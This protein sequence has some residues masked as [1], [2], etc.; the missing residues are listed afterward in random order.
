MVNINIQRFG[1]IPKDKENEIVTIIEEC[2]RRIIN[3][4]VKLLDLQLFDCSSIMRSYYS[5]ES[6]NVGV[7]TEDFG[8]LFFATH[9]AWRGIPRISVCL[10][11]MEKLPK[12]IRNGALRHEV[13]HSI[14]HGSLEYYI[15]PIPLPLLEFS[16]KFEVTKEYA[17]NLT[18]LISI[19]VKDYEVTKLL[20][21]WGYIEDQLN[22]S[23]YLLKTSKDDLDAW[24]LSDEKP[25]AIAMC[26]AGRLKDLACLTALNA[27]F[28]NDIRSKI[29]RS[30]LSYIPSRILKKLLKL[31]GEFPYIF[32][33]DT[34]KNFNKVIEL[35]IKE[36]VVPLF[37]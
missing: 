31:L 20:L 3:H 27:L 14:L 18:Y 36:I 35:F 19:A 5:E 12:L 11:S 21:K 6:K 15:F 32:V 4:D 13:G 25:L 29:I 22:Y 37:T 23:K 17:T 33:D 28:T 26:L 8:E 10:E 7:V 2:Y 9:D 30:E 1:Q 24:R 34:S 16:R